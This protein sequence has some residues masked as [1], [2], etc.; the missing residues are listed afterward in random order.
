MEGPALKD[1]VPQELAE[2]LGRV[3]VQP[4]IFV[5]VEGVDAGKVDGLV[6]N[7]GR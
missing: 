5:H 4:H 1:P 3:L 6:G 7:D 2:R